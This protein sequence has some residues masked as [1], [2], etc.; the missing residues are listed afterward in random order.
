MGW[1]SLR[2][3]AFLIRFE[4]NFC[5]PWFLVTEWVETKVSPSFT[6]KTQH[7]TEGSPSSL[8]SGTSFPSPRTLFWWVIRN[9]W[10]WSFCLSHS[11]VISTVS[12]PQASKLQQRKKPCPT[13]PDPEPRSRLCSTLLSQTYPLILPLDISSLVPHH[14]FFKIHQTTLSTGTCRNAE[15]CMCL[16]TQKFL[17]FPLVKPGNAGNKGMWVHQTQ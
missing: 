1:I 4:L 13:F 14:Y 8:S 3:S 15:K 11:S 12:P 2:C 10:A 16:Y 17:A 5:E 9:L 6:S 7:R